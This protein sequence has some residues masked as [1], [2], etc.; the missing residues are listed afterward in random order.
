[1]P[2]KKIRIFIS[3]LFLFVTSLLFIDFR[4]S[5][6][7]NTSDYIL[8]LQFVPSLIGFLKAI[9]LS[10]A[11]FIIILLVTLLWGR[12]YCSSVCPLGT[13]QDMIIKISNRKRKRYSFSYHKPHSIFRY[14]FLAI[15]VLMLFS[16]SIGAVVLLDPFSNFGKIFTGLFRPVIMHVNNTASVLLEQ[17][18]NYSIAPLQIIYNS[19]PVFIY[20]MILVSI[21]F[22]LSYKHG[23]LFCNSICPV[24]TLLGLLARFSIFKLSVDEESCSGCGVCAKVCKADCIDTGEKNIDFERCVMCFNCLEVCPTESI[25]FN[26]INITAS[27]A[28]IDN[29]KRNFLAQM[30]FLLVSLPLISHAQDKIEVY[31]KNKFKVF[32]SSPISPPGSRSIGNFNDKCIACHLC[33]SACPTGV[34]QPAFLEYGLKGIFQPRM[35]NSKGFCNYDCTVCSH[36]CPTDAIEKI[37]IGEKKIVQIGKARF[38]KDNCVVETQKTNCGACAEHCPT[39]AVRMVEYK[40]NLKIPELTDE[41]CIGCGA[42]EF[43]CPTIPYKAIYVDGNPVH[44]S[45]KLPV[46][47][48]LEDINPQEDFPF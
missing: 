30:S 39:K 42:C 45:A 28:D 26:K 3:L 32:R 18:N 37:F 33:V 36:V 19:A 5:Y 46:Q 21:I 13:L 10:S 1:M 2:L 6:V 48:D 27:T 35:D 38:I 17:F 11:G 8:F 12:V 23:R 22:V 14:S 44:L 15:T 40:D 16:G 29:K 4:D 25:L 34:L 31:V 24:G 9:T 41:I 47:E 43:A 7:S 20:S